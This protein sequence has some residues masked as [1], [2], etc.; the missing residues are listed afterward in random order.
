MSK[1]L[2]PAEIIERTREY[3]RKTRDHDTSGHDWWHV[4]RVT[5]LALTIAEREGADLFTVELAALLHDIADWKFHDGDT[6]IGPQL[7]RE[8]LEQ[9]PVDLAVVAEVE[10]IVRHVSFRGGTN[11]VP[12]RTL[13]G[14]VVQDADRLD[15][16]GAIGIA[17][18]F[19]FG[20]HRNRPMHDP[21]IR[22]K[23]YDTFETFQ[24]Q[25][26]Q[27]TT[28]N[29]FYEKLLLLKDRM[30]TETGRQIAGHRHRV[31]EQFLE[32]FYAEWDGRR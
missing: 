8:W 27:N 4:S 24:A 2:S 16:I 20:G 13:E 15:G 30:N 31:M 18:T 23:E 19:T 1:P 7:T 32:E 17:R 21:H 26:N 5:S 11:K 9:M 28:I 3:A 22:S 29:H 12:M 10:Y 25:I 6:D 14:K